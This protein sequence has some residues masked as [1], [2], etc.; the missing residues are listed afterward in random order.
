M[1]TSSERVQALLTYPTMA[2]YEVDY[3]ERMV[4]DSESYIQAY[5]N[6]TDTD[7]DEWDAPIVRLAV[8]LVN[9]LGAEGSVS[10]SEGGI[11]RSW[12]GGDIPSDIKTILKPRR[13]IVGLDRCRP[14]GDA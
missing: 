11:S 14:W 13:L 7:G 9:R 3:L 12:D 1:S 10:A 4:M 2:D 5:C 8:V 6:R